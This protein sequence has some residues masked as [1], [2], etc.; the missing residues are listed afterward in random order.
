[1]PNKVPAPPWRGEIFYRHT[2]G[3]GFQETYWLTTATPATAMTDLVSIA[4]A[5]QAMFDSQCRVVFWRLS[6]AMLKGDTLVEP[7]S[8]GVVGTYG[9]GQPAITDM[10]PPEVGLKCRMQHA[11]R[12]WAT[13][14]LRML[15]E[16]CITDGE[17]TPLAPMT[18]AFNS[19]VTAVTAKTTGVFKPIHETPPATNPIIK[20]LTSVTPL[21]ITTHKVGRP[22]GL[23]RARSVLR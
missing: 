2:N 19:W 7:A 1:M 15:P 5:R 18:T 22:F 4:T 10:M 21:S 3:H 11:D 14:I 23:R 13:R 8:A 17:W 16:D 9:V 20:G 6:D 12:Y